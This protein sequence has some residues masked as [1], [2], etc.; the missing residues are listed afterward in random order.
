MVEGV[1]SDWLPVISGVP[2]GSIL[3]PLLFLLYIN[4][5]PSVAR[6]ASLALFADDSKCYKQ[7]SNISDCL[8][9]QNDIDSLCDWSKK[10][11]LNFHPSKCQIICVTRKRNIIEFD[12]KMNGVVLE[13][14]NSIKDLG[15]D[16]S[17]TLVW[18]DHI[19]RVVAKCNKKLGM[20]K[21]AIGFNAPPKVSKTLYAALIRSDLEYCSSVW[22]GTSKRNTEVI[23]GV[24][25]RATKFILGYP[26][27]DYRDRLSQ[28]SL[29]PLTYRREISDLNCFFRCKMGLYDLFLDNY[30]QFYSTN[31]SR[32]TT[33]LSSDHLKLVPQLCK[34]E[35]HMSF[36]FQRIVPIWNQL[37]FSTRASESVDV[38]K[39]LIF[40]FYNEK[41]IC[42]FDPENNC[43]WVSACRCPRCRL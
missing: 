39:S 26:K 37:S 19:N 36:F 11:D 17:S 31:R 22:S 43:T 28:L 34:T 8:L 21:R 3:G 14:T 10:W 4:D 2:Q 15:V 12:Y 18:D 6:H 24:Q 16:I 5:M 38:F 35:S 40:D 23:E 41:F 7:I 13:R 32:P 1:H 30:V 33:R 25:R 29:L 42:S 20:I 9:L 27:L